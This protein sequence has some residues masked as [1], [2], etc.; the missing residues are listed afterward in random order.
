M[1]SAALVW[2]HKLVSSKLCYTYSLFE[3]QVMVNN[4]HINPLLEVIMS[5]WKLPQT[6]SA[7]GKYRCNWGF[8]RQ[9]EWKN[10]CKGYNMMCPWE[11]SSFPAGQP[12]EILGQ[13]QSFARV[14][15]PELPSKWWRNVVWSLYFYMQRKIG[16]TWITTLSI[17]ATSYW[18]KQK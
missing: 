1:F 15:A 16:H 9:G 14:S 7:G 4:H 11:V 2:R 10:C 17:N 8:L 12:Q 3:M 18:E 13:T 5:C 6:Y